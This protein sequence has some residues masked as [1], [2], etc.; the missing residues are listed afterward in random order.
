MC[1]RDQGIDEYD[2]II[3]RERRA[4]RL[5]DDDGDVGRGRGIHD[6]SKG[7]ET[8]TEASRIYGQ[9]QRLQRCDD[10]PEE[11][12]TTTEGSEAEDEL[13]VS[14]T[15]AEA[16]DEEAEETTRPSEPL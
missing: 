9:R 8:T 3:D 1:L 14:T 15:T 2:S 5:S 11:L 7:L 4:C 10:G 16:S 13:E 6:A 12:A